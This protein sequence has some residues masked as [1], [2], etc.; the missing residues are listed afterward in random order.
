MTFHSS[1]KKSVD[2]LQ[3]TPTS[4]ENRRAWRPSGCFIPND[5]ELYR[6]SS[7]EEQRESGWKYKEFYQKEHE[8]TYNWFDFS[9]IESSFNLN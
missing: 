2:H 1:I 8:I 3:G 9:L 4:I 7:L 5:V 6:E